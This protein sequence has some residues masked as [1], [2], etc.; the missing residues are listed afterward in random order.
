LIP[1]AVPYY[2]SGDFHAYM[3][4]KRALAFMDECKERKEILDVALQLWD[5]LTDAEKDWADTHE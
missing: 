1:G 4:C 5:K 3:A 2:F